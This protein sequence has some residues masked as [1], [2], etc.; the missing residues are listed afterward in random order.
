MGDQF[1]HIVQPVARLIDRAR[2]SGA[3]IVWIRSVRDVDAPEFVYFGREP[4][5][6][7]DG[8]GVEFV[9]PLTVH[10]GETVIEKHSHDCFA[11]TGLDDYLRDNGI[12]APEFSVTV[13]GVA[14]HV[15]VDAAVVGFSVRDYQVVLPIDC[16][17]PYEGPAASG[18]LWRYALPAYSYN[19]TVT[20][21]EQITFHPVD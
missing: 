10:Q 18:T 11:R 1:T 12:D 9:P 14:L 20:R 7:R 6:I 4:Y 8:W 5:L 2:K 16:V 21:S 19:I 3:R 13:V 17:A 15:C